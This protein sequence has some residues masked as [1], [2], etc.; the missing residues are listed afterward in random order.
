MM[1]R[2]ILLI[3]ADHD[4]YA[5]LAD[6]LARYRFDILV[7]PDT[8][9]AIADGAVDPPA[10]I[11]LAVDEPDKQGFKS[12]QQIKK[13]PLAGCPLI[14]ATSSVTGAAMNKHR[15]L[16][17]HADEYLDKRT[18][19]DDE[20]LGRLDNLI[21]LGDPA[22]PGESLDIPM[23]IDDIPVGHDEMVL[24]ETVGEDDVFDQGS[25]TVAG[26]SDVVD[27]MVAAETDAAFDA[28]LGG[29]GDDELGSSEALPDQT[30]PPPIAEAASEATSLA[31]HTPIEDAS[32][33][34]DTSALHE[35]VQATDNDEVSS[36]HEF[37]DEHHYQS[38]PAIQLDVDDIQQLDESELIEEDVL[39]EEVVE[40]SGGVPEPVPHANLVRGDEGVLDAI[41]EAVPEP[42]PE[43]VSRDVESESSPVQAMPVPTEPEP[44]P[45]A[46][47]AAEAAEPEPAVDA[48]IEPAPGPPIHETPSRISSPVVDL[49]LDEIA[50]DAV[51]EQSGV[52]DRRA[53]R[54]IGELERQIAQ[55]KTE[56]DRSRASAE[57]PRASQREFF[58]L[59]EQVIAK[60]AELRR[61]GNELAAKTRELTDAEERLR[62]VQQA[63]IELEAKAGDLEQRVAADAA[64]AG[65]LE[66]REKTL[67][68]Q[69]AAVQQEL[70]SRTHA[71][72]AAET[73]HAQLERD[74]ATERATRAASA[75][76][77]ERALRVEREQMIARHQG[78]LGQLRLEHA[79]A[80]AIALE[81]QRQEMEA[82]H[83]AAL[84]AQRAEHQA[85]LDTARKQAAAAVEAAR[86]EATGEAEQAAARVVAGHTAELDRLRADH[87]A[88]I[89]RAD[90]ERDVV[91]SNLRAEH[92]VALDQLRSDH[93]ATLEQQAGEYASTLENRHG[94]HA[95]ELERLRAE[96][97][98]AL[99]AR[100]AELDRARQDDAIAH[101][102][103]LAELKS[104]LDQQAAQHA[105]M[106]D[107]AKQELATAFAG[108]ETAR[109]RLA[110]DH[111]R[112]LAE[113]ATAHAAELDLL[114]AASQ[115][116]TD[117]L[118]RMHAEHRQALERVTAQ[119]Q[120]ELAQ[121]KET[122][123]LEISEL[124]GLLGNARRAIE[125]ATARHQ[126]EREAA[127]HAHATALAEHKAQHERAIAVVNGEVVKAKA[128]GDAE[129]SR[130]LTH[131]DTEH[132]KRLEAVAAE[133]QK[134]VKEIT[135]E[136]DELKRGLSAARD[137]IK[138]SE[139][140]LAAAVQTIADRNAELRTH[141]AGI[142]ERDQ[143]IAELRKEIEG[144]ETENASYQ[145]QVLR[146]Y[147]KIKSDEAN[148]A[149]A[150]KAMA[151]ALTVL[152]E[153]AKPKTEN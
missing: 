51:R 85:A 73:A 144:L 112:A 31:E 3:D 63:R 140:E 127:D 129:L 95:A 81:K 16:K 26:H 14:L 150:K 48:P 42:V 13:G 116:A 143:R 67:A 23:E 24:E 21:G 11:V 142:A 126:A 122:A 91:V 46:D 110:E 76:D 96:H 15:N 135:S 45:P 41:P 105:V 137:T 130:A 111:E 93:A 70:E 79:G 118:T 53:L 128:M 64:K 90:E 49:G 114:R 97:A 33:H 86:S 50:A 17:T 19:S 138:R 61:V 146:A 25:K 78:E 83:E 92:S 12:F 6:L 7:R 39:E 100:E 75:S 71:F 74:L 108:H 124:K 119:H 94:E 131:R 65:A 87:A 82:T 28:L 149:R 27:Q 55:L 44:E 102:A 106:L 54:Q 32:A 60:D 84:E 38:S 89:A 2:R 153:D 113:Q 152:D 115:S 5:R 8:D 4:F 18:L 101:T 117:D 37:D 98:A 10:L 29:F 68:A 147:Q 30:M 20:L 77:A 109:A 121:H 66:T 148:V 72:A 141:A 69:L 52:Y 22:S 35:V 9:E 134:A 151:I 107:A 103:K 62:Q 139:S 133:H 123:D 145:D 57:S 132:A 34:G 36:A 88:A 1:N 43:P 120:A 47:I 136:R 58:H 80:Q 104:Q 125:E 59:K 99:A 56:L 40:D